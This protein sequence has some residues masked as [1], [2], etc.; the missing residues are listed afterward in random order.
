VNI[1]KKGVGRAWLCTWQGI[2]KQVISRPDERGL[3]GYI[4]YEDCT[5][6]NQFSSI[7][8]IDLEEPKTN[9]VLS[10]IL[11]ISEIVRLKKNPKKQ[12]RTMHS[13]RSPSQ[14]L[15]FMSLCAAITFLLTVGQ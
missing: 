4:D 7:K 10:S 8:D 1:R 9:P 11:L 13:N 12:W 3:T 14:R 6:Q 15:V 2:A 5:C